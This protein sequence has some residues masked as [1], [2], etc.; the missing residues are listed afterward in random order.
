SAVATTV[1]E[2]GTET[3]SYADTVTAYLD[4]GFVA[5][6]TVVTDPGSDLP[7]LGPDVAARLLARTVTAVRG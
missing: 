2:G 7:V 5:S 6:V 3:R 4:S 1:V